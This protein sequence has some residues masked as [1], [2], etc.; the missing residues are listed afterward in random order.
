MQVRRKATCPVIVR[1]ALPF[2]ISSQVM[3]NE[4]IEGRSSRAVAAR[5]RSA[6]HV[7]VQRQTGKSS[8]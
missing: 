3:I 7:V 2:V 8:A 1:M 6:P 5:H 4:L